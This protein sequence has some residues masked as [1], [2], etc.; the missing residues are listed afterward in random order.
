MVGGDGE[1]V[2]IDESLLIKRKSAVPA[3]GLWLIRQKDK[4]GMDTVCCK[5]G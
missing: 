1:I 2:E 3:V 4:E 5:E